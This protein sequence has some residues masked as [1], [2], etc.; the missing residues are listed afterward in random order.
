MPN[1][2]E[3]GTESL[4]VDSF[5]AENLSLLI[6]LR[7]I[8]TIPEEDAYSDEARYGLNTEDN[9]MLVRATL[10][11]ALVVIALVGG[12]MS[13]TTESAP[14]A[15]HH[16]AQFLPGSQIEIQSNDWVCTLLP[17]FSSCPR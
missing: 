13:P 10:E 17:W 2:I 14:Q 8:F 12:A 11:S 4:F 5:R 6:L 3:P 15:E 9:P 16:S 1:D 7:N